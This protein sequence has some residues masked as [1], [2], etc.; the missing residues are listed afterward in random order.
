LLVEDRG[1]IRGW[2][3][4]CGTP[5][6]NSVA[7]LVLRPHPSSLWLLPSQRE[8]LFRRFALLAS[9]RFT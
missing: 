4:A 9:I 6:R 7:S 3:P 8:G 1:F 5:L 2:K